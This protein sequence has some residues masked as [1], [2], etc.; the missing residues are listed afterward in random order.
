MKKNIFKSL[1][2][3]LV[4]V[5]FLNCLPLTECI[6]AATKIT[7]NANRELPTNQQQ[8]VE[9]LNQVYSVQNSRTNEL[10]TITIKKTYFIRNKATGQY[11][12]VINSADT[13]NADVGQQY[14]S[15]NTNQKWNLIDVA[16]NYY[17]LA[18]EHS[19]NNMVLD[20]RYDNTEN[21]AQIQ[22]YPNQGLASEK[23]KFKGLPNGEYQILSG[24]TNDTKCLTSHGDGSTID[25]RDVTSTLDPSQIW[26]LEPTDSDSTVLVGRTFFIRNKTSGKY[27]DVFAS[28]DANN[29]N[30]GQWSYTNSDNQKW[31]FIDN[32]DGYYKLAAVH[33]YS[34]QVLDIRYDNTENGAEIQTYVKDNKY[35]SERFK[36]VL[37]A[38]GSYQIVSG[39]TNNTK[40]LTNYNGSLSNDCTIDLR[41]VE[42]S[43]GNQYNN[44]CW[45]LE[46][47]EPG[48]EVSSYLRNKTSGKY[49]D[50]LAGLDINNADVGQWD[51][52]SGNNQRWKFINSGSNHFKLQPCHSQNNMML[53]IRGNSTQNGADIQIYQNGDYLSEDFAFDPQPDGSY[54]I[55]S[56]L[57][58]DTKCL[59]NYGGSSANG[60]FIDLRDVEFSS[61]KSYN[62]QCWYLEPPSQGDHVSA[63]PKEGY[64]FSIRSR[65][66]GQ[67][68]TMQNDS[69]SDGTTICQT[70]T[71]LKSSQNFS[72]EEV[73]DDP[74]YYFIYPYKTSGKV[75]QLSSR[76]NGG[77]CQIESATKNGDDLQ[78]F[79]L[80]KNPNGTYH[81]TP[82]TLGT[83]SVSIIQN[84]YQNGTVVVAAPYTSESHQQWIFDKRDGFDTNNIQLNSAK[85][86]VFQ[87]QTISA[88]ENESQM[89]ATLDTANLIFNPG[90][91]RLGGFLSL[92]DGGNTISIVLMEDI[93]QSQ[94]DVSGS[95]SIIGSRTVGISN[96]YRV[97]CFRIEEKCSTTTLL[98]PNRKLAG[99][100]LISIGI[101]QES[102]DKMFYAQSTM[103][104]VDFDHLYKNAWSMN[105]AAGFDRPMTR[106][107]SSLDDGSLSMIKEQEYLSLMAYTGCSDK[108]ENVNSGDQST[109][110]VSDGEPDIRNFTDY[111]VEHGEFNTNERSII[112]DYPDI[113]DSFFI[114]M[115]P[116]TTK[117]AFC[118]LNTRNPY[119]YFARCMS[120]AG[121]NSKIIYIAVVDIIWSANPNVP[122]TY[123]MQAQMRN[124]IYVT[125]DFVT[126]RLF[127]NIK[128]AYQSNNVKVTNLE[129]SFLN[130][131]NPNGYFYSTYYEDTG[132]SSS[133][134]YATTLLKLIIAKIPYPLGTII[135]EFISTLIPGDKIHRNTYYLL[136]DKEQKAKQIT[137]NYRG[138][139]RKGDCAVFKIDTVHMPSVLAIIQL[140]VRVEAFAWMP[141]YME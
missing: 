82:K 15:G 17:N 43:S 27:L 133:S 92:R 20:I 25:L 70:Y 89:T 65:L 68:W 57:T 7:D 4:A 59:T 74:G 119:Y 55:L 87:D 98:G 81:I 118:K 95:R 105:G 35:P 66:S 16:N 106:A 90:T 18:P 63:I 107:A 38:D 6:L 128:K 72:F 22:I 88:I 139:E 121:T 136:N 129:L 141:P 125:Y 40:C 116:N 48:T 99:E 5:L 62:D 39:L 85:A 2:C 134:F 28:A 67:S 120:L 100:T 11:L 137:A 93:A 12:D 60:T 56:A 123:E 52:Y 54:Q 101:Y 13:N 34:G 138:M 79:R 132:K 51:Y 76:T 1:V 23:F 80:T 104:Q 37:Q 96:G 117:S 94:M 110:S 42:L 19:T 115:K 91:H 127:S 47:A 50:V 131:E 45:Y 130:H 77:Y 122:G 58:N 44:Q 46:P 30:V 126:G 14:F 78:K 140:T 135:G 29:A 114:N 102:T 26:Y 36:I 33:S 83:Y 109:K 21:G 112:P 111:M 8:L 75:L 97:S 9:Q 49:L 53:D 103:S 10:S 31:R 113:L 24:L 32:G 86:A 124:N 64:L 108:V 73:Q 3:L 84:Q 71:G 41:D 61:G 69:I